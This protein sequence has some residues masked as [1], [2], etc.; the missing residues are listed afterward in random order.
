MRL[1]LRWLWPSTMD[2]SYY[3]TCFHRFDA[4]GHEAG[5]VMIRPVQ[6]LQIVK[7]PPKRKRGGP[8]IQPKGV[9]MK[10]PMAFKSQSLMGKS[11]TLL[12]DRG[13]YWKV[14]LEGSDSLHN[15]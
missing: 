5:I 13:P 8:I 7:Q 10:V 12:G 11:M 3:T 1:F 9:H 2:F 6:R 14:K 4:V 15:M